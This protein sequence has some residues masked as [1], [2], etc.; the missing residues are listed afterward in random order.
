MMK[1]SAATVELTSSRCATN[2]G[3]N[4]VDFDKC[5]LYF[6]GSTTATGPGY[7]DTML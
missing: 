7:E 6:V 3:E 1:I 4:E 2:A 5:Y